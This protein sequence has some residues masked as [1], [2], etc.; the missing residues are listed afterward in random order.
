MSL[1]DFLVIAAE[2]MMGRTA[3]SYSSNNYFGSGTL[4]YAFKENFK[5]GR[6][7]ATTCDWNIG[8]MPDAETGCYDL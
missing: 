3:T 4:A 7:T 8:F 2:A 1:A 6:V 5:Y